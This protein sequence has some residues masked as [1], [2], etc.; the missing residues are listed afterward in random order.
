MPELQATAAHS[1]DPAYTF[2]WKVRPVCLCVCPS[3]SL[4]IVLQV[5]AEDWLAMGLV[6]L[7]IR[8]RSLLIR[9]GG[10]VFPMLPRERLDHVIWLEPGR[11]VTSFFFYICDVAVRCLTRFSHV[12][13]RVGLQ[14]RTQQTRSKSKANTCGPRPSLSEQERWSG[15]SPSAGEKK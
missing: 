13:R 2:H 8:P 15:S 10:S 14:A 7:G 11:R 1:F 4:F 3:I 5:E 12:R 9:R 6:P